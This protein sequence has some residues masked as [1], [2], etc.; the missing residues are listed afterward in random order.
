MSVSINSLWNLG[1]G[2]VNSESLV[3]L[4]ASLTVHLPTVALIANLPQGILS[5]L[6]LTYNGLM[7]CML[8]EKE[9]NEYAHHRRP[10]RVSSPSGDQVS[11]YYFQLPYMYGLPLVVLWALLHWLASESL[12]LAR[13]IVYGIDGSEDSTVTVNTC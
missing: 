7:T 3:L 2:N 1:F 11:A 5:V 4:P 6:Y 8:V 9:W 13:I 10:L 12:F